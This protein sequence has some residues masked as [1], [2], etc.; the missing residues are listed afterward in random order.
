MH[1]S[2]P[3][4]SFSRD[5]FNLVLKDRLSSQ[6][7]L[8]EQIDSLLMYLREHCP[9]EETD[10]S[11]GAELQGL[12]EEF[13]A[14]LARIAELKEK[15]AAAQQAA[16]PVQSEL[17]SGLLEQRA[18]GNEV[19]EALNFVRDLDQLPEGSSVTLLCEKFTELQRLTNKLPV[20]KERTAARAQEIKEKCTNFADADLEAVA[21]AFTNDAAFIR[22]VLKRCSGA[23]FPR[24][25]K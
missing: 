18:R 19:K 24:R 13:N 11:L 25:F 7:S 16:R 1:Y 15:L 10:E 2:Q 23:A 8:E 9:P 3:K 4:T 20:L 21:R 14:E 6:S 5:S 17:M 12:E 22:I